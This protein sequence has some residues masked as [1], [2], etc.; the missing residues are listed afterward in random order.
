MLSEIAT[1]SDW[2]SQTPVS[3]MLQT[4]QWII[5]MVQSVHILAIAIVMSSVV[6]V[7]LRLMGLLGHTQSI[8]GMSRRFLPWLWWSL[9][10][11]LASGASLIVAEP[12]RDLLNPV[13]QAKM[14]LLV[15]A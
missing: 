15:A 11:L 7:D 1:F 2:L 5:P 13:F 9:L 6:M 4:V 8:S 12:R 3:L 14:G 10:V